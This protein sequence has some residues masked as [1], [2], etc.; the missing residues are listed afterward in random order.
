M[1]KTKVVELFRPYDI[2]LGLK[3]KKKTKLATLHVKF[4]QR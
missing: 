1:P 2:V 3:L 4:E